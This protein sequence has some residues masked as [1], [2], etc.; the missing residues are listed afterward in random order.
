M[1]SLEKMYSLPDIKP[2]CEVPPFL[3]EHPSPQ[4]SIGATL[5]D[6]DLWTKFHQEGTEMIITKSGRRMFPQCKIR[7]AG[8]LPY[9]KY[10]LLVDFVP[11]DT[12]RYKWNK[13]KWEV[14]GKAEPQPPCRTYVHPDSPALGTHW[15]KESI[16]FH[17][18][19]L[20]NNTL[21]QQGHIILHSMHRY[22]PRIHLVQAED[23]YNVRW[24]VF[25]MFTFPEMTFTAVTA[26]QNEAVTKLKIEN[27][28]FAKGFREHGKNSR[29]ERCPKKNTEGPAK[30]PKKRKL[31]EEGSSSD[32]ADFLRDVQVKE[33]P[34][35]IPLGRYPIWGQDQD[36]NN[37]LQPGSPESTG[38]RGGPTREQQVPT[39]SPYSSYRF[40]DVG[41][42]HHSPARDVPHGEFRSRANPVDVALVPELETKQ[43][44]EGFG[45]LV[46]FHP[47]QDLA[48]VL[49]MSADSAM[50]P[51]LR[52]HMY[53]PYGSEQGL[54]QWMNP[55]QT[56]YR[57]V[58]YP[59]FP[60][61]YSA[62]GAS[63]HPHGSM[64]DWSQYP[65]FPYSCW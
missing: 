53:N 37:R 40:Q 32:E 54:G 17:K 8:L 26:Y 64:P 55:A 65:L 48:G 7:L 59:P 63:G 44:P 2:H 50:K 33:E 49:N 51:G 22:K 10:M 4:G 36:G 16:S 14:A 9:A 11:V 34:Q 56:Q 47:P 24:G 28:P 3:N 46:P 52:P 27:N 12:F 18:L 58:A 39:P 38:Q 57:P 45:A 62:Q 60:T 43:L 1:S 41:D 21:D 35:P 20:T 15:M 61:D 19:K 31:D 29:R 13:N 5:E 6:M 42:T 30:E 25:Q 23:L